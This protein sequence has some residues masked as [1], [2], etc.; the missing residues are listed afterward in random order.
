M[1]IERAMRAFIGG[2]VILSVL[3][4]LLHS[5]HWIWF[6]LFIGLNALQSAF[7]GFCPPSWVMKKLGMKTEAEIALRQ[8]QRER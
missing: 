1:S 2:M 8:F 7:T 6:T 5:R 3:L 4:I